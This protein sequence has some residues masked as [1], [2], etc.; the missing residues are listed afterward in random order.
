MNTSTESF[1]TSFKSMVCAYHHAESLSY[2][3]LAMKCAA[4]KKKKKIK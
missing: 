3:Y 1:E 2:K 4:K